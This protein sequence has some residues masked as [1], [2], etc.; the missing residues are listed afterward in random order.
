MWSRLFS[1]PLPE[2]LLMLLEDLVEAA[3][4]AAVTLTDS[5]L[6]PPAAAT[7]TLDPASA[8][9]L[10]HLLNP[11]PGPNMPMNS[12]SPMKM[13]RPSSARAS[14]EMEMTLLEPTP[15]LIL[16]EISSLSTTRL[17]LM[18]TLRLLTSRSE[19]LRSE[20]SLPE[21]PDPPPPHPASLQVDSALS[22]L[23]LPRS[24]TTT[25]TTASQPS[26]PEPLP[27]PPTWD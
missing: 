24:P 2:L 7:G 13:N 20:P 14:P 26:A 27:R 25:T 11:L 18:D 8:V 4:S 15:M 9:E 19:L 16:M 23:E 3:V 21:C 10:W 12:R 6:A 1:H 22:G 17:D 5:P